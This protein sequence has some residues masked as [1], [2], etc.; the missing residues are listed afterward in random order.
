MK[1]SYYILPSL[2]SAV[3]LATLQIRRI[4]SHERREEMAH[5]A[6]LFCLLVD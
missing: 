3:A 2:L 6:I 4:L 5:N 1:G